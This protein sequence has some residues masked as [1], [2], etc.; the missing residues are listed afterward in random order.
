MKPTVFILTAVRNRLNE[1]KKLLGSIKKQTYPMIKT[2]IV[3]DGST[4]GT[5]GY[6]K[7]N[8]HVTYIKGNGKLW[9][10]GAISIGVETALK[11]AKSND[12]IL[13]I[14]N[15][16]E[17]GPNYIQKLLHLAKQ[18]KKGI[19]GSLVVDSGDQSTVIDA[20]TKIDW[21]NYRLLRL[22]PLDIA[23]LPTQK[24]H[25]KDIDILSTK[26]TLFPVEVFTQIGNFNH[27]IFPHYLSDYE[28]TY[29]ARQAGYKLILSYQAIVYNDF[30]NTGIYPEKNRKIKVTSALKLLFSRRSRVNIIDNI[31]FINLHCP[32]KYKIRNY[33]SI[34][35]KI[36]KGSK[37]IDFSI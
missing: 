27:K 2:F 34:L 16:C 15:D 37:L 8:K 5:S 36:I 29:R 25:R 31:N 7:S 6:L 12:F 18:Y 20:G 10:T 17:F 3:D 4:D 19:I 14:N 33:Y 28:F 24:T 1:T 30:K 32:P 9:W 11:T 26:G 35:T 21:K 22:G 23:K 13:T